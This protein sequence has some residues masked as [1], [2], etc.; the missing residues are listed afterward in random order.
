MNWNTAIPLADLTKPRHQ[1]AFG[2]RHCARPSSEYDTVIQAPVV[3]VEC[4]D[5]V[6]PIQLTISLD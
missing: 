3:I 2:F 1:A 4:A 6:L 5:S